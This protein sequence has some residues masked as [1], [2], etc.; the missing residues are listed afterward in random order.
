MEKVIAFPTTDG[1]GFEAFRLY[2]F[3]PCQGGLYETELKNGARVDPLDGRKSA[4]L[5]D[6][7]DWGKA[8]RFI[9]LPNP[10]NRRQQVA[11]TAAYKA[12]SLGF[13]VYLAESKEYG[14]IVDERGFV[15][16]FGDNYGEI[17]LS[18]NYISKRC[19]SGWRD[20]V[21]G[22]LPLNGLTADAINAVT[23][24]GAPR[25][26]TDGEEVKLCTLEMHLEQYGSSSR[27]AQVKDL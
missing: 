1:N 24:Y 27:Y 26:A 17:Y 21:A 23:K 14:F 25:W 20:D 6:G 8:G 22:M 2:A 3:N 12:L 19:G 16:S 10:R 9:V 13:D 18:G 5:W 15:V 4:H 7:R 11:M